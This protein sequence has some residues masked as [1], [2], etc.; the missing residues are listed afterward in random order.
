MISK[1]RL[2]AGLLELKFVEEG[3]VTSFTKFASALADLTEDLEDDKKK[4]ID[5][6]LSML[7]KD[8]TR[9]KEMVDK[10]LDQVERSPQNEF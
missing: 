8:S 6:C 9:H 7:Y 4:E 1:K 10:M 5:K 3:M 2:L